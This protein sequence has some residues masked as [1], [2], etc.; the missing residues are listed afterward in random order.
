ML[1]K[2]KFLKPESKGILRHTTRFLEKL[3]VLK[4]NEKERGVE[5]NRWGLG[6][7]GGGVDGRKEEIPCNTSTENNRLKSLEKG[8]FPFPSS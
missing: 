1:N 7:G 5:N 8:S 6:V 3:K 4:W 2:N